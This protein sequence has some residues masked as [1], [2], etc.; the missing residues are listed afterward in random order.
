MAVVGQAPALAVAPPRKP[1][2]PPVHPL[3]VGDESVM[4]WAVTAPVL[5]AGPIARAH[6]PTARADEDTDPV[7]V[8][9]VL[10]DRVTTTLDDALVLGFVSATVIAE[11]LTAVTIPDA[12]P[13]WPL[14]NRLPPGGREPEAPGEPLP[15]EVPVLPEPNRPPAP[16]PPPVPDPPPVRPPKPPPK[17]PVHEPETGWLI[18]TVVAVIGSP[19]GVDDDD[20]EVGLP[21]AE[22]HEPTVTADAV[23]LVVW[24]KVVLA[25]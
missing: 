17:L 4:L 3:E 8:N 19:N 20:A 15:P 2:N 11:T 9:A 24:R 12:A 14:P 1:P 18:E 22:T 13:N 16:N 10:P 21:K 25:V 23:V 5:L 6:C 7:V